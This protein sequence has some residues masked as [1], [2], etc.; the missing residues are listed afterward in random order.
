[1]WE[2]LASAGATPVGAEVLEMW[3][4]ADG[5]PRYGVDIRERDLPQE[6]G[7]EHALN[8]KKGCYI[9]Q[10]IVERIRS[11]GGVH[12]RFTGFSFEGPASPPPGTKIEREGREVGEITSVAIL[13]PGKAV[14]LGYLRR[15]AGGP[16]T[17]LAVGGAQATVS[18]LPFNI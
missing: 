11:R 7:Q 1:M 15:E 13:P 14:G 10:E 8:F 18:E 2:A 3:R 5:I 4:I 12:R 9:G 16:G 6:S 17:T